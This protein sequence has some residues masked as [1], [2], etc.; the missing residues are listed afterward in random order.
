MVLAVAFGVTGA[1]PQ[2]PDEPAA[3]DGSAG[4]GA[5]HLRRPIRFERRALPPPGVSPGA[6]D[7]P[8]LPPVPAGAAR[9][10][11]AGA[12]RGR[13][14]GATRPRAR[15]TAGGQAARPRAARRYPGAPRG[16]ATRPPPSCRPCRSP[17]RCRRCC[18]RRSPGSASNA[19]DL[20]AVLVVIVAGLAY[21]GAPNWRR[22][23]TQWTRKAWTFG[24]FRRFSNKS[25][26]GLLARRGAGAHDPAQTRSRVMRGAVLHGPRD[27]RFDERATPAIVQPTDAVIKLAATCICGSDLWPYRGANPVTQP[28]RHGARI[29]RRRRGGRPRRHLGQAW[30][31][32]DRL[33]LRIRQHLSALSGRDIRRR[34][35]TASWSAARRRRSCACRWPTGPWSPRRKSRRRK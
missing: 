16:V 1:I 3:A 11:T 13:R 21:F 28:V 25:R 34:A 27:V 26:R 7:P 29:L 2:S 20:N 4:P 5:R 30:S 14:D 19:K 6:H 31:V 32:R 15:G 9:A 10:A 18:R 33:V 22:Q 35:S 23:A 24:C 17:G 12:T 8:P